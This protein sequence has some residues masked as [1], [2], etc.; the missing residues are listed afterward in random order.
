L[1]Q[2]LNFNRK[3]SKIYWY[4]KRGFIQFDVS[5]LKIFGMWPKFWTKCRRKM[6]C[7]KT[8]VNEVRVLSNYSLQTTVKRFAKVHLKKYIKVLVD[9]I[10]ILYCTFYLT[11]CKFGNFFYQKCQ[12]SHNILT[13][14]WIELKL[15]WL[16]FSFDYFQKEL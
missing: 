11:F 7:R 14:T 4:T 12:M 13:N 9:V 15:Q 3:Q 1:S 8:Y 6:F 2:S 5:M 10:A 16:K